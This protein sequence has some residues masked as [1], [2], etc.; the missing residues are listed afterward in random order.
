MINEFCDIVKMMYYGHET[1][2][3]GLCGQVPRHS[4]GSVEFEKSLKISNVHV[5]VLIG[6]VT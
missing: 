3:T 4:E 6:S 1:V 5:H 2:L